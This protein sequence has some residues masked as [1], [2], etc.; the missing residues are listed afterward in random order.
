[1]LF[2][3]IIR[4][5]VDDL[6][7]TPL[8]EAARTDELWRHTCFEAFLRGPSSAA[9]Y[10]FNFAPS[11]QWAAYKFSGYRSEM[12]VATEISAPRIAVEARREHYILQ[13]SLELDETLLLASEAGAAICHVGL[14]AVIEET[15]GRRSYWALA[16]PSGKPDFHH[17]DCFALEVRP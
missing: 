9:Y 15:S 3:Y 8:A 5:K 13:A 11:T 12:R 14:S 10:E 16:H 4:G 17:F 2:A 7:M 1:L 6:A